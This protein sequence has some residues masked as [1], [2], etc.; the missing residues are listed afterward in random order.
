VKLRPLRDRVLIRRVAPEAKTSG[1][2]FI[3]G[4][5]QEKVLFGKWSGAEVTLDGGD[6]S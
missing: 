2:I 6:L 3:P 5:A 1:G 4:T